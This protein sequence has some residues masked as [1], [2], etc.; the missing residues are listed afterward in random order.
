MTGTLYSSLCYWNLFTFFTFALSHLAMTFFRTHI[1]RLLLLWQILAVTL[2]LCP[3]A[4]GSTA[5]VSMRTAARLI[6][7]CKWTILST[8]LERDV[9]YL[10]WPIAPKGGRKR[11]VAGSQPMS[12]AVHRSPN[13]LWRSNSKLAFLTLSLQFSPRSKYKRWR[14]NRSR[15]SSLKPNS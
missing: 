11:G 12:T 7:F 10:G 5:I 15:L 13:K 14:E 8:G 6:L 3:R 1:L 9:D 2:P 4:A